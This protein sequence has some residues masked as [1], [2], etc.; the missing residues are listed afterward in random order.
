M[1]IPPRLQRL[2][3]SWTRVTV[4]HDVINDMR[5]FPSTSN[6]WR[7]RDDS[8]SSTLQPKGKVRRVWIIALI[9]YKQPS[10]VVNSLAEIKHVRKE[11][12]S[13]GMMSH[14]GVQNQDTANHHSNTLSVVLHQL[15]SLTAFEGLINQGQSSASSGIRP[16]AAATATQCVVAAPT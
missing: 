12:R 15:P 13:G 6:S 10:V 3:R 9:S 2:K 7:W 5:T 11:S 16:Q 1:I 4:G 14:V 8:G